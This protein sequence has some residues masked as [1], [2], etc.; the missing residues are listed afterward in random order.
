MPSRKRIIIS[1]AL[2][3]MLSAAGI[4]LFTD[5]FGRDSHDE[6]TVAIPILMYHHFADSGNPGTIVSA[7]MFQRQI[8]ALHSAGYTAISFE[9][10]RSFVNDGTQL[11]DKPLIITIDDGYMSVYE[12]AFPI[13]E[14][15]GMKATVFIM[16]VAHG[17]DT[18]KDTGNPII[19]R[20]GD[21]EALEMV[22]SGI[23]SI[24]SH[25]YDMHQHEPF[26]TGPYRRGVLQRDGETEEEYINAFIA[27]F[28]SA[29]AQIEEML[30][31]RPFVYSYPFGIS[32]DLT[33]GLLRDMGVDVT[34]KIT[35]G[36]NT[37]TRNS[38]ESLFSL[39]RFNVPGDMEPEDLLRM[40][41]KLIET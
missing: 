13:L 3:L 24:Q 12:V 27:D 11:P 31:Y 41:R 23:I 29:A 28:E 7:E 39:N 26:E 37:I 32:N 15:Y 21:A 18:Y 35:P 40:I 2:L 10:L 1:V 17:K 34:V 9:E 25:S 5:L 36:L 33:D 20:F 16:G 4:I 30:G 8:S 22:Q 38:P 6:N 19:P 14:E